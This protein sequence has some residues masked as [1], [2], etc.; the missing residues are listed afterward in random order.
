[1]KIE[2][3]QR[4]LARNYPIIITSLW[5]PRPNSRY[6]NK[7]NSPPMAGL[8][9]KASPKPSNPS[10]FTG[11][12][13]R[14]KYTICHLQPAGKAKVAKKLRGS[15]IIS[16]YR[17]MNLR[18]TNTRPRLTFSG[19]SAANILDHLAADHMDLDDYDDDVD[20]HKICH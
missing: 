3:R 19:F 14:S 2:G 6:G 15:D 9:T 7:L 12:C 17:L 10:K 18:V 16:N 4:G 1:M 5:S 8:F 13:G 20:E 11:K